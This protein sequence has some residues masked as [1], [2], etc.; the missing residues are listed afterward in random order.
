MKQMTWGGVS[1]TANKLT[2]KASLTPYSLARKSQ[3]LLHRS[4]SVLASKGVGSERQRPVWWCWA[5]LITLACTWPASA[6]C[7]PSW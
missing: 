2:L 4:R 7:S 6:L 3:S 5:H 1:G